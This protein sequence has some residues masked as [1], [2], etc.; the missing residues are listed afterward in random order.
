MR[1]LDKATKSYIAL[2]NESLKLLSLLTE[3]YPTPFLEPEIGSRLASMID[4]LIALLVGPKCA[5]LKVHNME[6]YQFEPKNML[7]DLVHTFV[8]L[9]A[10][11]ENRVKLARFVAKDER[12]FSKKW[13]RKAASLLIRFNILQEVNTHLNCFI[14][15]G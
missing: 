9:S 3:S 8:H 5:S 14:C 4:Y 7:L 13:F 10:S 12:S 6:S 1:Q 11:V 15:L 2:S